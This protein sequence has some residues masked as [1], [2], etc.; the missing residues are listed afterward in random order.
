MTTIDPASDTPMFTVFPLRFTDDV[1][2]MIA[3]LR[4][5][6]LERFVTAGDDAFG[7]LAAGAGR[8]MVHSVAG[9]VSG[10]RPGDTDLC[11]A[12]PD[13][14]A[15]A[16]HLEEAG[17]EVSV[18]DESFGRQGRIDGPAGEGISLNEDQQDLYGYQGHDASGADARLAVVAVLASEDPERDAA[19]LGHL[20]LAPVGPAAPGWQELRG[21]AG[22]AR[23]VC[24]LRCRER[25]APVPPPPST[26]T[27]SRCVWASPRRRISGRWPTGSPRPGTRRAWSRTR[28]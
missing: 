15:A 17:V 25:P 3:F 14:D 28:A 27:R 21:P 24:T 8:V 2:T 26:A 16:A 10:A 18:W 5:L 12:V 19:H 7:D 4:T 6:G 22:R 23:S 11:L 20:G 13:A 1:P 9:A